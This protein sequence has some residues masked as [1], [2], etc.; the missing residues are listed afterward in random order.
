MNGMF[1]I[2][3]VYLSLSTSPDLMLSLSQTPISST[4][5]QAVAGGVDD[6]LAVSAEI[7]LTDRAIRT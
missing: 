4:T 2:I 7:K 5:I 1:S 6:S 3:I